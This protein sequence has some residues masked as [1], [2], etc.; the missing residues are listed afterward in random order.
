M[1]FTEEDFFNRLLLA[2]EQKQF[3]FLKINWRLL[4]S[5]IRLEILHRAFRDGEKDF[6]GKSH[7]E[8]HQ[9]DIEIIKEAKNMYVEMYSL[10]PEEVRELY[11]WQTTNMNPKVKYDSIF[12]NLAIVAKLKE[13]TELTKKYDCFTPE[14][15]KK[16][17]SILKCDSRRTKSRID[18][19]LEK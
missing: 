7:F 16:N 10:A 12:R 5:H 8:M 6:M 19:L 17:L 18:F 15:I 14:L 13:Y 3:E 9:N 4:P 2:Y 1:E 11:W